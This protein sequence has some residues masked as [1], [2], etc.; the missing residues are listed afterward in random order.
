LEV[1][2]EHHQSAHCENG[3]VSNLLK[4]HN[5]GISEPMVFGIG[6]GLFFSYLPFVKLNGLP[7]T[8]YRILP[9][10]IFKRVSNRLGISMHSTTFRSE[11]KAMEE[12]D[13][14][15]EKGLPV[16]LLT[17]V[18]YLPYLPKA[19]RFHFN[20]HNI[21]VYGKRNGKYLVSDPVLE[22]PCEIDYDDLVRAR[23]AKG[24]MPPKGKMYYPTTVPS[25]VDFKPAIVKGIKQTATDML[26]V[27]IP[28]FGVKG[29]RFLAKSLK[30]WPDKLDERRAIL[31]LGQV[32]RMQE[33]IGTG[34][35]GFRFI[36]GAFLQEASNHL[37]Q[38][39]L[40]EVAQE[41]T[42]T[43]DRWRDFA[44]E[45]GRICKGRASSSVS[46]Q[47]LSDILMECADREKAIFTKLKKITL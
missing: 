2:F 44:F 10:W 30:R 47:T 31:Y 43:G 37:Q 3:A 11:T 26:N 24:T 16:G 46:Y 22:E 21:V 35:G 15:L 13:R 32:I 34:G 41:V 17:S 5:L 40:Q 25:T 42:E 27:P 33:E 4:F 7:V 38:P 19:L 6:S 12:L 29:I 9:G 14:T 18:F 20:A 39:W 45:A 23:F 36:F 8:S 28:L 1:K